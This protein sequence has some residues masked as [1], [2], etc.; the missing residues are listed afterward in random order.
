MKYLISPIHLVLLLYK[1]GMWKPGILYELH[2]Y[3]PL[4]DTL[5]W[6][7]AYQLDIAITS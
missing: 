5:D 1:L 2:I 7:D 4:I 3:L 6:V